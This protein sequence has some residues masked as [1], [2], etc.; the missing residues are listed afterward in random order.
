MKRITL[1]AAGFLLAATT[2]SFA[3]DKGC[4]KG[5]KDKCN[6][7]AKANCEKG[8]GCCKKDTAEPKA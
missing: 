8:K 7:E 3:G 2:M 6:K 5:K 4:C 1:L